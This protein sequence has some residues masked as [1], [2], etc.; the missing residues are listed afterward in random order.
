M[1]KLGGRRNRR[2][3][4]DVG[5]GYGSKEVLDFSN[6]FELTVT[7]HCSELDEAG[8]IAFDYEAAAC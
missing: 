2:S 7:N 3:D 1:N 6:L 5:R 4:R 8:L